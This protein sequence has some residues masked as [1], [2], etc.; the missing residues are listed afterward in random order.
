MIKKAAKRIFIL[1]DDGDFLKE[2]QAFLS[3]AGYEVAVCQQATRSFPQIRTFAPDC[4]LLDVRMPLFDA[5]ELLPWLR[6]QWPGLP[7]VVVT[8]ITGI[9]LSDFA[10]FGVFCVLEKPFRSDILFQAIENAIRCPFPQ[11]KSA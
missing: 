6:R 2:T 7:I 5:R 3:E 8:G 9:S 1:D 4:M 10:H 11:K